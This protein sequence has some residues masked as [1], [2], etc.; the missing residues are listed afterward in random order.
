MLRASVETSVRASCYLSATR[1]QKNGIATG[2]GVRF[3]PPP[4]HR[5][6]G[7]SVR[8][9]TQRTFISDPFFHGSSKTFQFSKNQI[10]NCRGYL[11]ILVTWAALEKIFSSILEL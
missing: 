11:M 6:A 9:T 4:M 3:I 5:I 2:A 7:A 10:L 8:I 1:K